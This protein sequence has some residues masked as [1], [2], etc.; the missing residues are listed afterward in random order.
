MAEIYKNS[1]DPIRIK[2]FWNGE[3]VR[4]S[5]SVVAFVYDITNDPTIVPPI[6]PN[7]PVGTF[8]ATE[9]EVN[10]GTYYINLPFY[11]TGR[12]KKFRITWQIVVGSQAELLTSYCDVVT[13]YVSIHEAIDDLN[14]GSDQSD[15]VYKSYHDI[16][17]AEKYARKTI[18]YYT[19][20][21]F[22]LYDTSFS[23][24]GSDSGSLN[25]PAKLHSLHKLYE[26]DQLWIDDLSDT[27]NL[28]YVVEPTNSG[29]GIKINQSSLLDNDVYIANG[30]VPPSIH[31]L[32]PN[33]FKRNK[34]YKVE[35]RFGWEY[36]P[37]QVE[38]A[39][40]QIMGHYFSKD[41]A[42]ADRY[43]KKV[44]TFDWDFE[45]GAEVF[46]GTGCAYADKLLSDYVVNQMVI[47]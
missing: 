18:E 3:L 7:T 28:G 44:S 39:A 9:D 13:P 11:L 10:P 26:N 47:V 42:W 36:V 6:N 45:Y 20:Q 35:G 12:N 4:S 33:V 5:S 22:Y 23:V 25:L 17:M 24:M 1:N 8:T 14:L 40:I 31:D 34:T 16:Q 38:Q 29:F 21:K 27:N 41:T 2:A 32:S 30:M 37:D 15:P 43:I 19:K 46:T